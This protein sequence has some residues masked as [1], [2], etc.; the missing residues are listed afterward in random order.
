MILMVAG[1][2]APHIHEALSAA[3]RVR[4]AW[5]S[6]ADR[7]PTISGHGADGTPLD[8]GHK[9]V[10]LLPIE[11][12]DRRI[13]AFVAWAPGGLSPQAVQAIARVTHIRE[14]RRSRDGTKRNP[15]SGEHEDGI[16]GRA[17][18]TSQPSSKV[19]GSQFWLTLVAVGH[20]DPSG[21]G[22]AVMPRGILGPSSRWASVTPFVPGR[23]QHPKRY[24]GE[25]TGV[26][27]VDFV[28]E[29]VNRELGAR[30]L[31]PAGVKV[32]DGSLGAAQRFTRYRAKDGLKGARPGVMLELEFEFPVLGPISIG[33]YN[34]F[35]LGLF[36]PLDAP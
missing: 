5:N 23:H 7:D 16:P 34:H 36:Q 22:A 8:A 9:H 12:E 11:S 21:G 6:V 26:Y 32:L 30:G 1:R 27:M 28:A 4:S 35:G 29:E 18:G 15:S 20:D 33:R 24:S 14:A 2:P 10:H 3:E 19:L 17:E 31:P 25:R 13:G